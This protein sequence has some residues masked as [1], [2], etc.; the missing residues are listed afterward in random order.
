MQ[1]GFNDWLLQ[2][3]ADLVCL[4]ET[5][6]Q[7]EQA[8]REAIALPHQHYYA[9]EKKGYSGTA[10]LAREACA[11]PRHGWDAEGHPPEGRVQTLDCGAFYLV[12]VYVPNAQDGLRRLDYR[13]QWD[14]DFRGHIAGLRQQKPV[15]ACGDFNCAHEEIDLARP[16][17]NR[18]SAGFSDEE[19]ASFSQHLT[20][21]LV[22]VLRERHP[23]QPGLYTWWS[24]RG[25]AR[26]R[27]VGWRLD[28]FLVDERLRA[29][30]TDVNI[31]PDVLGSDHCPISLTLQL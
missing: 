26:S 24:Y 12:N 20:G 17:A 5:K 9:A 8:P 29:H 30:V 14:A 28:Y 7:P 19:R 6:L 25:G 23:D 2:A 4:Q 27:N 13:L 16:K 18:G 3:D 1:K 15:V 22:D 31:H 11:E 21:G 10:L